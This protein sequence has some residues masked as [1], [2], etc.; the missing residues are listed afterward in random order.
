MPTQNENI[1][2]ANLL[3][4]DFENQP[5]CKSAPRSMLGTINMLLN[6]INIEVN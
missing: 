6:G 5:P 2:H 1:Q 3:K 4:L